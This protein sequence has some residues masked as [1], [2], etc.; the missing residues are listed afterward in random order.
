M[1]SNELAQDH[2]LDESRLARWKLVGAIGSAIV[3]APVIGLVLFFLVATVVPAIPLLAA[4]IVAFPTR[5]HRRAAASAPTGALPPFA[6]PVLTGR[7]VARG[8]S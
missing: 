6:H 8:I 1:S 3:M 5:T 2:P 4:L 7:P